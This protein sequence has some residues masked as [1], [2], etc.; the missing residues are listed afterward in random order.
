[1]SLRR[2]NVLLEN[3]YT[4]E[5]TRAYHSPISGL[6][7]L[8]VSFHRYVQHSSRLISVEA[9]GVDIRAHVRA[10]DVFVSVGVIVNVTSPVSRSQ[11]LQRRFERSLSSEMLVDARLEYL[12]VVEVKAAVKEPSPNRK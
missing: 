12:Y 5:S 1:M 7:S 11:S 8:C 10:C 2:V 6:Q 4:S 9:V 3:Q